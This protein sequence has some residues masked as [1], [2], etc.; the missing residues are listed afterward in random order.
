[1][2]WQ[3]LTILNSYRTCILQAHEQLNNISGINLCV[4][5]R[6][7]ASYLDGALNKYQPENRLRDS[8]IRYSQ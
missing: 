2:N 3:L 8:I 4:A 1:M 7:S 5:L 6:N